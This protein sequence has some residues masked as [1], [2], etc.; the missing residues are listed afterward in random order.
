MSQ[1]IKTTQKITVQ[2]LKK[3]LKK[4]AINTRDSK[5]IIESIDG[6]YN[7]SNGKSAILLINKTK[8]TSFN[9][10]QIQVI[11]KFDGEYDNKLGYWFIS[12]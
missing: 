8:G 10:N 2:K 11:K 1:E 12:I 6:R 5:E 4:V 3:D 9:Y 7:H